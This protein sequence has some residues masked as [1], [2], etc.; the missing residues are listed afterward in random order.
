MFD[1]YKK[2]KI[3]GII[4]G[5]DFHSDWPLVKLTVKD[6]VQKPMKN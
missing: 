4:G 5:D 6:F 2:L 1:W 3:G